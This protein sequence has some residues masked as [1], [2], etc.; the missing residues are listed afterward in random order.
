[1]LRTTYFLFPCL[2]C[3]NTEKCPLFYLGYGSASLLL[4]GQSKILPVL[5]YLSTTTQLN[6]QPWLNITKHSDVPQ[7]LHKKPKHYAGLLV[8]QYS[9]LASE[10]LPNFFVQIPINDF[11]KSSIF[12]LF[13]YDS[14]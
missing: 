11:L 3:N 8:K 9:C 2:Y 4:K 10:S 12:Q 1:M 14:D 13:R 7:I 5:V 6:A